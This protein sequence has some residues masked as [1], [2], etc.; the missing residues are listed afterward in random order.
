MREQISQL[1]VFFTIMGAGSFILNLIG[2]Q[3][4]LL[5]W[6]DHWGTSTGFLIRIGLI[7]VGAIL[8]FVTLKP[9]EQST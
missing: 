9:S 7:I 4:K 1:G 2:F 6:I 5:I 3:F 8:F